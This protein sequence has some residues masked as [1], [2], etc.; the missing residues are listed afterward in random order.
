[1]NVSVFLIGISW[2]LVSQQ[3]LKSVWQQGMLLSEMSLENGLSYALLGNAQSTLA[4]EN[5]AL[6]FSSHVESWPIVWKMQKWVMLLWIACKWLS[7][8]VTDK[9]QARTKPHVSLRNHRNWKSRWET[10]A[11]VGGSTW[12]ISNQEA[13]DAVG[14]P[15]S[16]AGHGVTSAAAWV[17][18]VGTRQKTHSNHSVETREG[19]S[20]FLEKESGFKRG[21]HGAS[22]H[23]GHGV[24]VASSSYKNW[25][26]TKIAQS[27][28][29]IMNPI[30]AT[31]TPAITGNSNHP[32]RAV[33]GDNIL[34]FIVS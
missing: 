34:A 18:W 29:T 22:A 28:L 12:E 23:H 21:G 7:G 16:R 11:G 14:S 5:T 19:L 4:S 30:L 32:H 15:V 33:T 31:S 24:Q 10:M 8:K 17:S 6:A 9:R 13:E 25:T 2:M 1:M 27:Q 20:S 26:L 3:I